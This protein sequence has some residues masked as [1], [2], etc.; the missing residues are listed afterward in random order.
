MTKKIE[1]FLGSE[2]TPALV[3]LEV[4][5]RVCALLK[6][7]ATRK[8]A[9]PRVEIR[10]FGQAD[11]PVVV[12]KNCG[13][14]V[15]PVILTALLDIRRFAGFFGFKAT[16]K[17]NVE[18]RS[19]AKGDFDISDVGLPYP[20][21][22]ALL[23]VL[24]PEEVRPEQLERALVESLTY[25]N[26]SIAHFTEVLPSGGIDFH[27]VVLASFGIDR[28]MRSMVYAPLHLPYPD[29]QIRSN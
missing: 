29:L 11:Q 9:P 4:C 21:R 28:A 13:I 25:A 3:N 2:V 22:E 15:T 14:F 23:G 20:N 12:G 16:T 26:K 18:R 24:L 5:R 7:Y 6:D 27:Y 17:G 19:K 10:F 1:S 8:L